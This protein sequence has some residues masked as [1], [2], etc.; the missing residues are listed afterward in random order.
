[1]VSSQK[2]GGTAL[3]AFTLD[4]G[5]EDVAQDSQVD[6]AF[7]EQGEDEASDELEYAGVEGEVGLEGVGEFV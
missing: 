4:A 2:A 6:G 1:L 3:I 5:I 7:L